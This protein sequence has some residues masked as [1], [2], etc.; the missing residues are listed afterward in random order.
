MARFA[1]AGSADRVRLYR[2]GV[3]RKLALWSASL[4][5]PRRAENSV[6]DDL[7]AIRADHRHGN[8][9]SRHDRAHTAF[10]VNAQRGIFPSK[11][12]PRFSRLARDHRLEGRLASHTAQPGL[13]VLV[14]CGNPVD[15]L[16]VLRVIDLHMA[17]VTL[18]RP[19][20]VA[21]VALHLLD[22][23]ADV[24][25]GNLRG[26]RQLVLLKLQLQRIEP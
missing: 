18:R 15:S 24:E 19:R 22:M 1:A 4:G 13:L 17:A 21:G 12:R 23:W 2:A 6:P 3:D 16:L 9:A 7:L 14:T 10:A 5:S 25:H 26:R 20:R 11:V 8:L